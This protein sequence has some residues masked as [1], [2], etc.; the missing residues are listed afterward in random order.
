MR[1]ISVSILIFALSTLSFASGNISVRS[2]NIEGLSR[3]SG[4]AVSVFY[5]SGRS[6]GFSMPGARPR[7]RKVLKKSG[8]FNIN[9]G[10]VSVSGVNFV[11]TGWEKFNF[12]GIVV[13]EKSQKHVALKN[14]DGSTPEGQDDSSKPGAFAQLKTYFLPKSKINGSTIRL[15]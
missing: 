1:K 8:P 3:Y 10:S 13:H 11:E 12:V 6:P 9:S 4:K 14:L 5:V 7:I 2:F 15:R